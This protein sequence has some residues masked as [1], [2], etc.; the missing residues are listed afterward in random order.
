MLGYSMIY[1]I[2][3]WSFRHFCLLVIHLQVLAN[4]VNIGYEDM[5]NEQ[6]SIFMM[7]LVLALPCYMVVNNFQF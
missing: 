6:A 3:Y 7:T 1:E 2:P 4:E 5:S